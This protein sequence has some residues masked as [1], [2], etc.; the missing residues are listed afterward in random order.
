MAIVMS[1]RNKDMFEDYRFGTL[2]GEGVSALFL[3]FL[4]G[5]LLAPEALGHTLSHLLRLMIP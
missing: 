1:N 3:L 4:A 5:L 2:L